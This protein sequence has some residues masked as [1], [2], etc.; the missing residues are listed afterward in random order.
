MC[1]V[2]C[3]MCVGWCVMCVVLCCVVVLCGVWC[4]VVFCSVRAGG[5]LF[6]TRTQYQGALGTNPP[7]PSG[8]PGV[9]RTV[10]FGPL[11]V[12]YGGQKPPATKMYPKTLVSQGVV[13]K[14]TVLKGMPLRTTEINTFYS[15]G[16]SVGSQGG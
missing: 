15:F 7:A 12:W 5:V 9:L 6:K 14:N 1:D 13:P 10:P 3:M 11:L 8:A 16:I 4:A 2:W